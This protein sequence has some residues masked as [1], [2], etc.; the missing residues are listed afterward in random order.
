M[1]SLAGTAAAVITAYAAGTAGTITGLANEA[2]TLS[3]N[4]SVANQA[5]LD[6]KTT[7]AITATIT[8]GDMSTLASLADANG[9]N[10]LTVTVTDGSVAAAA[11]NTLNGKTSV[12]VVAT[13]PT[14]ITGTATAI[15]TVVD[16]STINTAVDYAVTVSSTITAAQLKAINAD[17]S[18]AIVLSNT[19]AAL[20]GTASDL[21]A[22]FAGT[23]TTYTG[24]ATVTSSVNVEKLKDI[25]DAVSGAITLNNT[26]SILY[27]NAS[28]LTDALNGL[29]GYSGDV[30]N[31]R[32]A[33]DWRSID[34]KIDDVS[35]A[36]LFD[37]GIRWSFCSARG[38]GQL[39]T[40]KSVTGFDVGWRT[41]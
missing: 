20:S 5:T 7:G 12:A 4:T 40:S 26:A 39:G 34:G 23:V 22:A 17:T 28:D 16:S 6:G 9:N 18:G 1:R 3:G 2:L 33:R 11:L 14:T 31:G 38:V 32:I 8:E 21:Q 35:L 19:S 13:A 15:N 41:N 30:R 10:A 27:G 24:A 25:N 29:T 37:S 36:I